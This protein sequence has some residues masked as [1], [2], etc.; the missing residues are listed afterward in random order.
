[1]DAERERQRIAAAFDDGRARNVA[2]SSVTNRITKAHAQELIAVSRSL[3]GNTGDMPE[4]RP[5]ALG[6]LPQRCVELHHYHSK[7]IAASQTFTAVQRRGGKSDKHR[8]GNSNSHGTSDEAAPRITTP[9]LTREARRRLQVAS[10]TYSTLPTDYVNSTFYEAAMEVEESKL[11]NGFLGGHISQHV[12]GAAK[13]RT[14]NDH[15]PRAPLLRTALLPGSV[16]E[17]TLANNSDGGEKGRRDGQSTS[18]LSTAQAGICI[19]DVDAERI[20]RYA[21]RGVD[22][23]AATSGHQ[24]IELSKDGGD[25]DRIRS[26]TPQRKLRYIGGPLTTAQRRARG[27]LIEAKV[28]PNSLAAMVLGATNREAETL[29]CAPPQCD[30]SIAPEPAEIAEFSRRTCVY[31]TKPA[32][33]LV[34]VLRA[35]LATASPLLESSSR[36]SSPPLALQSTLVDPPRTVSSAGRDDPAAEFPVRLFDRDMRFGPEAPSRI[37]AVRKLQQV[38][39]MQRRAATPTIRTAVMANMVCTDCLSV[40]RVLPQPGASR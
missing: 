32:R 11:V 9:G 30:S 14:T 17:G 23:G 20:K 4:N 37:T 36:R 26:P 10:R 31:D 29:I 8:H 16:G 7:C 15:R 1:M 34:D 40:N 18:V 21:S 24:G 25:T 5:L 35:Q 33:R 13:A 2:N 12:G 39:Q 19:V 28:N 38:V 3:R 27:E 6:T 22:D